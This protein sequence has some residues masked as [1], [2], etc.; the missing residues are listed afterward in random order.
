M[1]TLTRHMYS[2]QGLLNCEIGG[3]DCL[4]ITTEYK[5]CVHWIHM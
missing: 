4:A 3:L 2:L 5:T 1:G